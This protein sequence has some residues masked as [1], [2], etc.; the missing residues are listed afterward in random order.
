MSHKIYSIMVTTGDRF[1]AG[2]CSSV[3]VKLVGTDGESTRVK[4]N[5][6]QGLSRD[7]VTKGSP[8]LVE[9]EAESFLGITD[10]EWFCSSVVVKTPEGD[11]FLF[12]CH[13]WLSS[14]EK[15]VVRE[16]TA[17]LIFQETK[18][19]SLAHRE[20]Q[21]RR[22]QQEFRWEVYAPG[23]PEMVE[24]D[25]ALALPPEVRF[26]FTKE[27]EFNLTLGS[28]FIPLKLN[29]LA[30]NRDSW[31]NFHDLDQIFVDKKTK[32][33][34]YVQQHWLEDEFFGYQ[35]LN[36]LNPMM[37]ERCQ[38]LPTN[39]PVTDDL[40][41]SY[42]PSGSCLKTEMEN[43]NVFL[44]D[45][46]NLRSLVGK[47]NVINGQQQYLA[48]P[49]CLLYRNPEEKL[50]PVAIQ[51]QQEPGE[52][53]PI[54]L[55]SDSCDW[56]LAKIFVRN[57]DFNE[58]ELNYHLL[59]THLIAEVF[60]M[61]T[62]R[63]LPSA[64]PVFKLLSLHFRYTLQI[65]I[66]A[67]DQLMSLEGAI[68]CICPQY[69]GI[70]YS[71]SLTLLKNAMDLLTY[72]S[73]CL[74]ENIEARGLKEI[75][76][77]YYRD[78]GL[79]LWDIIQ[80]Y[81]EGVLGFYYPS[82]DYVQRDSEVQLWIEDIFKKGFVEKQSSGIPQSFASVKE[83][84]KFITMVIFTVSGQHAAINNG[85]FD[86]GGWMP[87]FPSSLRQPAPTCK[88]ETTESDILKTLPDVGTTVNTLAAVYVLSKKSTDHYQ[89]G[90]YPEQLFVEKEPLERMEDFKR[91]LQVLSYDIKARNVGLPLP[92]TYLDPENIENSVA[93]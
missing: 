84:I 40:V 51:L 72:T 52:G 12:P 60:A 77:F 85:Q 9:L 21:L 74:P 89:L 41:R 93:I 18:T 53:N 26:S 23:L 29:G 66:M 27:A 5:S 50:L 57:A 24:S 32:A 37:I 73:L 15:E 70:G 42:L 56:T 80:T 14:S 20:M 83:L 39:F 35:L 36:G 65:N 38:T 67:R 4:I 79:R 61:A 7:S 86:F 17:K 46:K 30:D 62:V 68:T 90:H 28:A 16:A 88:G 92:Y 55:P 2:T 91:R 48:A 58:H 25:N 59:R 49:L 78:D 8:E 47:G 3:Y 34:E 33:Y 81:V 44:C 19:K 76:T 22:C 82:D 10:D 69:T 43:G 6:D 45:Y 71:G 63:H 31:T 1:C 87:N 11:E 54:F 75:S 13:C 64:H